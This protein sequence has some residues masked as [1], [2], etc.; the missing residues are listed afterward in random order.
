MGFDAIAVCLLGN[1]NPVGIVFASFII[2]L[3]SEGGNYMS[4]QAG[5]DREISAVIT[6]L[7][8]LFSACGAYFKYKLN[9]R[10][11]AVTK[12]SANKEEENA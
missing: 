5:V 3:I 4:S 8:L 6:G 11:K 9:N 1:S 7:I 12:E 10:E 2:N